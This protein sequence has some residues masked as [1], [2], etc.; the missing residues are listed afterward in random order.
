MRAPYAVTPS[1][2]EAGE[3][4]DVHFS[5][6]RRILSRTGLLVAF[7]ARLLPQRH[8]LEW[9]VE[10]DRKRPSFAGFLR[11]LAL[12]PDNVEAMT[13]LVSLLT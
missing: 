2:G 1:F 10:V 8:A 7:C 13:G 4:G 5:A 11:V 6:S 3:V 9:D 12:Q